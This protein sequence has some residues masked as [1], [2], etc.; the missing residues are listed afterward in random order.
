MTL[1]LLLFLTVPQTAACLDISFTASFLALSCFCEMLQ[2]LGY[3]HL[4]ILLAI[5]LSPPCPNEHPLL[6]TF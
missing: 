4:P 1:T 2:D 5:S 6:F 3:D